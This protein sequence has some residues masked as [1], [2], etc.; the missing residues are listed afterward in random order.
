MIDD[1]FISYKAEKHK[2]E[3]IC[4]I[5]HRVKRKLGAFSLTEVTEV[6]EAQKVNLIELRIVYVC[7]CCVCVCVCVCVSV[8]VCV[9]VRERERERERERINKLM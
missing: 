3:K 1:V 2:I 7:V 5:V 8:C 6:T 4:C 9:C